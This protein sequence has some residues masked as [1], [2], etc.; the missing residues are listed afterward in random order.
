MT[1]AP[2]P[3]R[4]IIAVTVAAVLLLPGLFGTNGCKC[5][6]RDT[7]DTDDTDVNSMTIR[8]ERTL[9][10]S[11]FVPDT[12]EPGVGFS[13]DIY[14]AGMKPGATVQVG[15]RLAQDVQVVHDARA[16][17]F[18]PGLV[19]GTYDVVVTNPDGDVVTLRRALAVRPK[20][21]TGSCKHL[22]VQFAF[23]EARLTAESRNAIDGKLSCYQSVRGR[24]RVEGH[25]DARGTTDYNLAL[26]QFRADAVQRYMSSQ[27]ISATHLRTVSYGEEKPVDFGR[28]ESSWDANRRA[29]IIVDD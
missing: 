22:V 16:E 17:V 14:G 12:V 26:G 23:D 13:A 27:G 20:P 8:M 15:P 1:S 28:G 4:R 21:A 5:T 7:D 3:A 6:P 18:V 9:Q 19:Q 24:I 11:R 25:A 29:E 2:R 10:I